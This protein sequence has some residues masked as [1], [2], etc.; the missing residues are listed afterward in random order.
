MTTLVVKSPYGTAAIDALDRV[1]RSLQHDDPFQAVTV[2]CPSTPAGLVARRTMLTL[3]PGAGLTNVGFMSVNRIAEL[4]ASASLAADQRF[5]ASQSVVRAALRA[6]L[7][8]DPGRF[9]PCA[10]HPSTELA[11]SR[12]FREFTRL[13]ADERERVAGI[14][15]VADSAIALCGGALERL[16]RHRSAAAIPPLSSNL[17]STA[18]HV[19]SSLGDPSTGGFYTAEELIDEATVLISRRPE[20]IGPF[21]ALVWYLPQPIDDVRGRFIR[22]LSRA[23]E[24]HIIEGTTGFP[25][26][27]NATAGA[28]ARATGGDE[29]ATRV[30][31]S[32]Q[33]GQVE[34]RGLPDP[35]SEVRA[36]LRALLGAR[37]RGVRWESMGLV[38]TNSSYEPIAR[39][40]LDGLRIPSWGLPGSSL[41]DDAAGL[42]FG[43][44]VRVLRGDWSRE[45]VSELFVRRG[46]RFGGRPVP[47]DD[48]DRISRA[49]GVVAGVRQWTTRVA[50]YRERLVRQQAD[51]SQTEPALADEVTLCDGLSAFVEW[52]I[53]LSDNLAACQTWAQWGGVMARSWQD[54]TTGPHSCADGER[55][56]GSGTR[57]APASDETGDG[58]PGFVLVS[59]LVESCQDFDGV[60]PFVS[61]RRCLQAVLSECE[62]T[63]LPARP[64]CRGLF[65]GPIDATIGLTF[66]LVVLVGAAEGDFPRADRPD[67]LLPTRHGSV[68]PMVE[69]ESTEHRDLRLLLGLLASAQRAV[70][71]WPFGDQRRGRD[72]TVCRWFDASTSVALPL[73]GDGRVSDHDAQDGDGADADDVVAAM[74]SDRSGGARSVAVQSRTVWNRPEIEVIDLGTDAS[75]SAALAVGPVPLSIDEW[76]TQQIGMAGC[77]TPEDIAGLLTTPVVHSSQWLDRSVRRALSLSAAWSRFDGDATAHPPVGALD[78][79]LSASRIETYLKCPRRWLLTYGLN[80]GEQVTPETLQTIDPRTRGS[81]IH[82]VLERFISDQIE[83]YP[84]GVPPDHRWT[85]QER[86]SLHAIM[87]DLADDA[88]RSGTTGLG[89]IWRFER[90]KIAADIERFAGQDN[91]FRHSLGVSPSATE[92]KFGFDRHDSGPPATLTLDDGREVRFRGSIDRVDVGDARVVVTD[93]KT[94]G[95]LNEADHVQLPL[96]ALAWGGDL[97]I[98]SQYWYTAERAQGTSPFDQY[99]FSSSQRERLIELVSTAA[100]MIEGGVFPANP[101][102][103]ESWT[104]SYTNCMYCPMDD[105]CRRDRQARWEEVRFHP[106]VEPLTNVL[107]AN[108]GQTS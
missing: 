69:R 52:L 13:S 87:N 4:V 96:Y 61:H 80:V 100:R 9:A 55:S 5:P 11:L 59:E 106:H 31:A 24:L 107:E 19:P 66:E 44:L 1:V 81:L 7:A 101:G 30:P 88:E 74:H 46:L 102:Q 77:S 21:G 33:P 27:D 91:D 90:H 26:A 3:R 68:G 54:I 8:H 16:H 89:A 104:N 20:L 99:E 56:P 72:R 53:A 51:S 18:S 63:Q 97:P 57:S 78:E 84:Q 17:D 25:A 14:S 12:T 76:E 45:S 85:A 22:S 70:V 49:A 23:T 37:D 47:G 39:E 50:R 38:F 36:G 32:G 108:E 35:E 71:L 10:R 29:R 93:Y 94:G 86:S 34:L 105:V 15:A 82:E 65:V 92:W 98:S 83:R 95:R 6:Q 43:G 75:V 40:L 60:E 67:P 28:V 79:I 48:W 2:L 42:M 73:P 103:A 58:D 41:A 64:A 62:E